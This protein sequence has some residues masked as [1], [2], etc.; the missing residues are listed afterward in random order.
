MPH[1]SASVERRRFDQTVRGV[2]QHLSLVQH[3]SGLLA[4]RRPK[5]LVEAALFAGLAELFSAPAER[6]GRCVHAAVEWSKGFLS[7]QEC[8]FLNAA[9]RRAAGKLEAG[10]TEAGFPSDPIAAL[11][12]R[13]SHPE[14]WVRSMAARWG[15]ERVEALVAA[16]QQPPEVWLNTAG[17]GLT[18][19][20]ILAAG[21]QAPDAQG[22]CRIPAGANWST[23][24][25]WLQSGTAY[26]QSPATAVAPALLAPKAGER[27]LD[28]CAA[29][30]G[31]TILL[32]RALGG[33]GVVVAVDLAGARS[34]RLEE[35]L[36]SRPALGVKTVAANA[37]GLTPANLEARGLPGAYDA[38]L[39]D[40]PCSNSGV[41]R[42]KPDS[43]WRV[44]PD[45]GAELRA[46]QRK[47]LDTAASLTAPGGR[48]AYSTCS[49][50]WEENE[51]AVAIW[52]S[53]DAGRGFVLREERR[54]WPMD[55][56]ADGAYV[57]LLAR[58]S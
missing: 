49:V 56:G 29:P 52:L 42:H 25:S 27:V 7:K 15:Q 57:A 50:D 33:S 46:L 36:R 55:T 14:A 20:Q 18:A 12:L 4:H 11:A 47:L 34:R 13:H 26:V 35:N 54:L 1:A 3:W 45:G 6:R 58:A 28:T 40:A 30:G 10:D 39:V 24:E 17:G 19:E 37:L 5:R 23:I 44:R 41:W 22:F 43:K 2:V 38:I 16:N 48:I 31:K 32:A 9:L 53:S 8:G 51:G 21:L